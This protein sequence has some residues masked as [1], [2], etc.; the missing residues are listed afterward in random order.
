MASTWRRNLLSFREKFVDACDVDG[1]VVRQYASSEAFVKA[2]GTTGTTGTTTRDDDDDD[3]DDDA[4]PA[5]GFTVWDASVLLGKYVGR[6]R[7]WRRLTKKAREDARGPTTLELGAGTGLATMLVA[8]ARGSAE[9][10]AGMVCAMTDLKRVVPLTRMNARANKAESGGR[11]PASVAMATTTLRWGRAEDVERLPEAI[12][13]PDVVL[14][15][16]LMYTSDEGV[17]RALAATTMA[18]VGPGRAA[19]F[20]ACKEHRPESVELFA[21]IIEANGF[22]VTRV[23]ASEAHPDYPASNEE[24]ELL[25]C[26]RPRPRAD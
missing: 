23:P 25:E 8:A 17:I 24:F 1:V 5:T 13:R 14:G 11:I 12:R 19:V 2:T 3:D 18:L 9:G 22:E 20:A 21:S 16:D 15:A 6:E 4:V 7:T 26:W 10:E